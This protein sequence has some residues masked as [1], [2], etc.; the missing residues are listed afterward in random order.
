MRPSEASVS[1]RGRLWSA[2]AKLGKWGIYV[3]LLKRGTE[4]IGGTYVGGAVAVMPESVF[5]CIL[6]VVSDQ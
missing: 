6:A 2:V 5:V 1:V 3:D 4:F